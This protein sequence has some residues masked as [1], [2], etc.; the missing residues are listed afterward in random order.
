[1]SSAGEKIPP[2]LIKRITL[3]C[4]EWDRHGEPADKRGIAACSLTCRYWAQFLTPLAFRRLVLRTATDIVRLLAF[5]A[6]ADARTPPL[7]AC[8]KKI[9]FAQARATSKIPW[10]HQLVRLAQQLPNVN[11]QS[12]VRLTVTGGDGSDGPAQATD[13]TF[14]LPFRALPRTLPAACSKL[15]YVTLRDLH[16]ES[17]RAL[18]DCVKNL[19]A[20]YLILDGVTF[21]DEAMA[22]VRR[23]PAR[24]WA[25]LATIVVT[26]CFDESGVAQ[27]YAL[28]NL[29]FASQGC[30]YA[31]DEALELGEKCLSLALSCSAGEDAR[32]WFSV[33]YDFGEYRD[34]ELY[35]TYGF[36]AHCVEEGT[37]VR[38]ELSVPEKVLL[39]PYVTVHIEFQRKHSAATISAVRW[40]HMER[41]LLK[42]VETD[43]LWFY[44]HCAT[45]DVARIT[46]DL[47][48]EGKILATLC[49]DLKRVR[50]VVNDD[51]NLDVV[52]RLTSAKILSAPVSLA[53]G[54][55][56]VTLDTK[57]RVEWLVRG[58]KRKAYLLDLAR[59][60]H[61]AATLVDRGDRRV[62]GPSSAIEK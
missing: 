33:N 13:D 1:M 11:F 61:E 49:R 47:I 54:S 31:G 43:K 25:E 50:M 40:D 30:M 41:E 21:A 34:A 26:R 5:L 7:R 51:S 15:D 42:L 4:V 57:K 27:P 55:I 28:S 14:L 38:M 58:A 60:A 23:R 24:R 29:L 16:V 36:R 56:T 17:V 39:P 62:A 8:V 10:C 37:E 12:D 52:V 59:E 44:V 22:A 18:T 3:Y 35:H 20:R 2:E 6:D 53:A 48:L 46:L 9:E 19:A 45:P 32:P